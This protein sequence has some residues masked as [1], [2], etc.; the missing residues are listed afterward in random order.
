MP[1]I[2]VAVPALAIGT[3]CPEAD[4]P[5]SRGKR[6]VGKRPFADIRGGSKLSG[7][8]QIYMAFVDAVIEPI[9]EWFGRLAAIIASLALVA[10][11]IAGVIA[12][13]WFYA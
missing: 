6:S 11:P 8:D 4:G 9:G 10:L 3:A 5:L 7:M 2:C 12:A 13:V 1:R